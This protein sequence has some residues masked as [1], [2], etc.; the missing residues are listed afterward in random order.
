M[1][2]DSVRNGGVRFLFRIYVVIGVFG[3]YYVRFYILLDMFRCLFRAIFFLCCFAFVGQTF[4][5]E[6]LSVD[7]IV[8]LF[9]QNSDSNPSVR[10]EP[11]STVD[12]FRKAVEQERKERDMLR[13]AM[14][15][16]LFK[17][18]L[19]EFK[20][21]VEKL[22]S[23]DNSSKY[24]H[25]FLFRDKL[26]L[27]FLIKDFDFLSNVDSVNRYSYVERDNLL[28]KKL[29]QLRLSGM[30]ENA[31]DGIENE[32]DR[33]F[34]EI[35]FHCHFE[36]GDLRTKRIEQ[37]RHKLKNLRQLHYL[38]EKYW[39]VEE[40]LDLYNYFAFSTGFA[41]TKFVG[42]I[43]DKVKNGFGIKTSFDWVIN[44]WFSELS[45][46]F[47]NSQS[48]ELDSISFWGA[49][50]DFNFGYAFLNMKYLHLYG[51]LTAGFAMNE[52][53]IRRND[54]KDN[55]SFPSQYYP[56]YGAGFLMDVFFTPFSNHH[57][58]IR[59]R[60][61]IKNIWADKVVN[62]SGY[63]MYVS[64]ELLYHEYD[65]KS[66]EFDYLKKGER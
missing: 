66:E 34:V 30:F 60:G 36:S 26:L 51:Y 5:E 13:T 59:F 56:T 63:C 50:A 54:K 6:S 47:Y 9:V 45:L 46:N 20:K 22:E 2:T 29:E 7:S 43:S 37:N 27:K 3:I 38:V 33:A 8:N 16:A 44:G 10:L 52:L 23:F 19:E 15:N 65:Y 41:I 55:Y 24:V 25:G 57:F 48:V 28:Y 12:E 17:G 61:G 21:F 35:L 64:F 58:G 32:S 4:A 14:E 49:G 18:N 31:F 53:E 42:P 40:S 1:Q 62:A 11:D 39:R